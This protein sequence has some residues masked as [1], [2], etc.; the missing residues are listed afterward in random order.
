MHRVEQSLRYVK[1]TQISKNGDKSQ[2]LIVTTAMDM[3]VK[4]IYRIIKSRWNI[5]NRAFS[6]LKNNAN[7]NHFSVYGGNPVAAI[8][9]LMLPISVM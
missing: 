8:L 4:T 1:L 3:D 2:V 5:E 7:L 9:Y 6:N